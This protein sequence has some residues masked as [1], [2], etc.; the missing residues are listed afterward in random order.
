MGLGVVITRPPCHGLYSY[1]IG[2]PGSILAWL[3]RQL[4][5]VSAALYR[6]APYQ[7]GPDESHASAASP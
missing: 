3:V 6:C 2:L 1:L 4:S 5:R 7:G